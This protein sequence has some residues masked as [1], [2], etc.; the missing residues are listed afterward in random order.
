MGKYIAIL[1][2]M[3][4]LTLLVASC[5]SVENSVSDQSVD[6]DKQIEKIEQQLKKESGEG[7]VDEQNKTEVVD[8]SVQPE[9]K[10][11]VTQAPA[12][13]LTVNETQLVKLN[14]QYEDEGDVKVTYSKPL[15]ESGEWQTKY[16]D[17]G[18]YSIT[19]TIDDGE[20]KETQEVKLI[21]NKVNR[22]PKIV[23]ITLD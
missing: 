13:T 22:P 14:V 19:I 1:G 16:G 17:A 15:N 2:L 8:E 6:I 21:V 3:L 9:E 20:F 7:V 23:N 4:I 11:E 12:K 5:Q 18:E 10:E